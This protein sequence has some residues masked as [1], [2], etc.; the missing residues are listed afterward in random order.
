MSAEDAGAV[1]PPRTCSRIPP[2]DMLLGLLR[3]ELLQHRVA[4]SSLC[5]SAAVPATTALR[6]LNTLIERRL[7]VR[8]ADPHDGRRVFVELRPRPACLCGAISQLC[9]GCDRSEPARGPGGAC[10]PAGEQFPVAHALESSWPLWEQPAHFDLGHILNSAITDVLEPDRI[11]G[12]GIH[13]AGLW[14]A[15]LAGQTR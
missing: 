7:C 1:P 2:R 11:G 15:I 13:H 6:W 8:R 9:R 4:V 5:S 14:V 3:A 12:L 10:G